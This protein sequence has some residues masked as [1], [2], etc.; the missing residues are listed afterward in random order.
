[1][2]FILGGIEDQVGMV[3]LGEYPAYFIG[4][5]GAPFGY[6]F[7]K[8]WQLN[9]PLSS[10]ILHLGVK[11]FPTI[12]FLNF[13]SM[14]SIFLAF[15]FSY[16][17]FKRMKVAWFISLFL[18]ATFSLSP[19]ISMHIGTHPALL[20]IW[21]IPLFLQRILLK[22]GVSF[23][24]AVIT[25]FILAIAVLISNYIGFFL[26]LFMLCF[27]VSNMLCSIC[28][29]GVRHF[30]DLLCKDLR[31][32]ATILISFAIFAVPFLFPYIKANYFSDTTAFSTS[33]S[34][35]PQRTLE[36]FQNFSARPWYYVLPP[37]SHPILGEAVTRPVLEWMKD[38]WGYFLADDYFPKEHGGGYLGVANLVIFALAIWFAFKQALWKIKGQRS[39]VKNESKNSKV[40]Y[41]GESLRL[42]LTVT[43][44]IVLLFLFTM[45][46]FFTM[47]G[48]KIYTL[49]FVLYKFFP[50]FRVTARLGIVILMCVLVVNGLFLQKLLVQNQKSNVKNQKLKSKFKIIIIIY[51]IFAL[52][53]F[54]VP[55]ST[56]NTSKVPPVYEYLSKVDKTV[57]FDFTGLTGKRGF[58]EGP[59]IIAE[60]PGGRSEDIFWI[61][62]HH[63]G[64]INPR[65]YK[66]EEYGFD[67]DNF[68]KKLITEEGL[69]N[70]RKYGVSFVIFHKDRNPE[71]GSEGFF[72]EFLEVE[73]DFGNVIL[74]RF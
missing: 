62:K 42:V 56:F 46:P 27:F 61:T 60:Y 71:I 68:T 1:M 32:Y 34:L 70:A 17:L 11:V 2:P 16:T 4:N 55:I 67:S 63:K 57:S 13:V 15:V 29:D 47:S 6:L 22:K 43:I 38:D 23:F 37:L 72:R 24:N 66:N 73:R 21:L 65:M 52:F 28:L 36:D 54:Y 31:R 53:E 59:L 58:Y 44:T 50:M 69:S 19:Y 33:H 64:F 8:P 14:A 3:L 10:T 20:Q 7:I 5:L 25:G 51:T 39:K 35:N 9:E 74:F 45:P 26:I 48:H 30:K 18:S 41:S 40:Y 49:G 12:Y